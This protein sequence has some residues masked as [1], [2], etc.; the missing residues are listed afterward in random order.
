MQNQPSLTCFATIS[1]DAVTRTAKNGR[2]YAAFG[3]AMLSFPD[4]QAFHYNVVA[5]GKAGAYAKTL[6]RGA[7]VKLAIQAY[8]QPDNDAS[9]PLLTAIFVQPVIPGER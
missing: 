4:M 6:Q 2:E 9:I 1:N 7:Q 3:I 5:F 8:S